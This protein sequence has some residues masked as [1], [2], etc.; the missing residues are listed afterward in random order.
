MNETKSFPKIYHI[1][2]PDIERLFIGSVEVTEKLDGSQ[3]GFGRHE[4]GTLWMRSKGQEIYVGSVPKMFALAVATIQAIETRIPKGMTFYGEYLEKPHHNTMV[5]DRVPKHN[6]ALFGAD[7]GGGWV[8]DHRDLVFLA[9]NFDIDVVPLLFS[10]EIKNKEKLDELLNMESV[11]GKEKIEGIV[12]K[13]YNER[14][15]NFYSSEC[16]GKLVREGFKER[17]GA[18]QIAQKPTIEKF[19]EQF[20]TEARWK[21]AVQ[22]LKDSDLL[23]LSPKD[24]GPLLKEIQTDLDIEEAGFI[25]EELYKMFKRQILSSATHGFPEWYK[26]SLAEK[27]FEV[28][29]P[30]DK[31]DA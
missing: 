19:V 28:V 11:L 23:T 30:T 17:N 8:S 9:N 6:I 7:A 27:A 14:S 20:K 18:T 25:K 22:H 2:S 1:G 29:E 10:G 15:K 3:F 13:N 16:F 21:K 5:Y 24:I 31:S 26:N 4:D 12:V